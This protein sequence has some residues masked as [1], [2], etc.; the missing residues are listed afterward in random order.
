LARP[1]TAKAEDHLAS[2][3]LRED[4]TLADVCF[5]DRQQGWAVGDR[6]AIWHTTDGGRQ[7]RLQRSGVNCRLSAVCFVSPETGWAAGGFSHPY[8]HTGSGV[9]LFTED[10]GKHWNRHTKLLLPPLVRMR[11]FDSRVGVAIALPSAMFPSGIFFTHSAGRGWDPMP[12]E[13]GRGLQTGD[14]LDVR[15]GALA[16][17]DVPGLVNRHGIIRVE[18]SEPL[19]GIRLPARLGLTAP[20]GGWLIGQGGLVLRTAER[21]A[22]WHL[23]PGE[24]A[25]LGADQFNF[26]A[27][28][29]RGPKCWIAGNP[30]SRVFFTGDAG[31]SWTAYS[32]GQT[33]PLEAI[34]FVDDEHGWAVGHLGTILA[35]TDGGQTWSRQRAGGAR[36]TLLGVFGEP[37]DVP[38]E[39]F[40]RLSG[41]DGYL[42]VAEIVYR[43]DTELASR[44]EVPLAN[45]LQ[46]AMVRAG[47]CGAQLAWQFPL[48]QPG[49]DLPMAQV[50]EAWDRVH[51]GRGLEALESHLVRTIRTWRP[52]VIV[53]PNATA[54]AEDVTRLLGQ[55]VLKAAALAA[56]PTACREQLMQG[57]L[58]PW[59]TR[60]I[61]SV[62]GPDAQGALQVSASQVA[63]QLGCSLGDLAAQA[64]AL[65]EDRFR[66]APASYGFYLAMDQAGQDRSARDFFA[67]L[68]VAPGGDARRPGTVAAGKNPELLRRLAQRRRSA[69]AIV[70]RSG[71]DPRTRAA[72]LAEARE[73]T[74]GLDNATAADILYQSAQRYHGAGDWPLAAEVLEMLCQGYADEPLARPA[75]LWL[76][77]Y[78]ASSEAKLRL[79]ASERS[80][81]VQATALLGARDTDLSME[82]VQTRANALQQTLPDLFAQPAVGFSLAAAQRRPQSRQAERFYATQRSNA[83]DRAWRQCAQ[84]EQW[85]T[86]LRGVP[87][88]PVVRCRPT[89]SRPHLDGKL[90]DPFW[91]EAD[92][93]ALR[94]PVGDD[95]AWPAAVRMAYD[96]QFLYV[97][98][99][100]RKAPGLRYEPASGPRHR[101][102]DLTSHDRVDLYLDLDRDYA[103]YF[104]LAIDDRGCT[105]EDCWGDATWD[106]A[107]FVATATSADGWTAEIAIPFDQLTSSI[108]EKDAA[109]ALGV[110]RVVPGV[111][112]QSF[113]T[114]AAIQVIPEGFGCLHFE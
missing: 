12:G 85:L 70:E 2:D 99:E 105:R 7:W 66:T 84:L 100:A 33:A 47:A 49:L 93:A 51:G 63:D 58:E 34:T 57:G 60:R 73:L 72:L 11:F 80:A 9:L 94:S 110:V 6:G 107:W 95:S 40:V 90:D 81:V 96:R 55:I 19:A 38:W 21:G 32:T 78:Y 25:S 104:H 64:R 20:N 14:F 52:D 111:G 79:E 41:N 68:S 56:E 83:I 88:K 8:L 45:R 29:V 67:G 54:G 61:V 35:T 74:E 39:L 114:P 3:A 77:Q 48:R 106:P 36:A 53:A 50:L 5:V 23:P 28:E 26:A 109:W 46:E 16:G 43:R 97:A 44:D 92:A 18:P 101:D 24:L 87:P 27:L 75:Q 86:D 10:G 62:L 76:V 82:R 42:A 71:Q 108:P 1:E 15:N 91:K 13:R 31:R 59:Q 37:K 65:V 22:E 4:A 102:A 69:L 98:I 112:L 113:S 89:A 103:T 17:S 30:G